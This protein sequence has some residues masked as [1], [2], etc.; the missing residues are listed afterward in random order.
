MRE[1]RRRQTLLAPS[2]RQADR[3]TGNKLR[4]F[5]VLFAA[6]SWCVAFA[7]WL[8]QTPYRV[9]APVYQTPYRVPVSKPE[10]RHVHDVAKGAECGWV[11]C[12]LT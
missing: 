6:T 9:P 11:N 10:I 1:A 7:A 3:K 12:E 5:F 2:C 8:N 4:G